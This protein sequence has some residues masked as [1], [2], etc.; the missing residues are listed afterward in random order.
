MGTITINGKK[1]AEMTEGIYI[2]QVRENG[3][4]VTKKVKK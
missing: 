4:I 1:V 2:I 3:K